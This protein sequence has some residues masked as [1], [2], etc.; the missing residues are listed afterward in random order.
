MKNTCIS[1][2]VVLFMLVF[3][4]NNCQKRPIDT[5]KAGFVKPHDSVQTSVYWYWI[6]DNISEEG[7]VKDLQA[8]KR[9]GINRAF[10]GNIGLDS[11]PPY[12]NVKVFSQEWWNILHVA[13][14]TATEL[15]IDIGMFNSPGWS[16]SGGPWVTPDQAMRFITS[17][18]LLVEGGKTIDHRLLDVTDGNRLFKVIAY[19]VPVDYGK[20]LNSTN[21]SVRSTPSI[22]SLQHVMDNNK[23]T[24]IQ[25]KGDFTL[26]FKS[27]DLYTVRSLLIYTAP[28]VSVA[29]CEFQAKNKEGVLVP[30]T[31]FRI[32]RS[33]YNPNV[34]FD[35]SAPIVVSFADVV[36]NEFRL[37]FKRASG[38]FGLSEVELSSLPMVERYP[39]KT[40]AKMFQQPLPYW[41]EYQWPRQQETESPGTT[42][43]PSAIVDLTHLVSDGVLH[44]DAPEGQWVLLCTG[45]KP[46]GVTNAP[47]AL[48]ATGLEVDK[49]SKKHV[50]SHFDAFI[51]EI[52]RRIPARDRRSFKVVVADSYETGG[53]NYSDSLFAEFKERY[54]YDPLPFLPVYSGKVVGSRLMSDRFLWDMR[55]LIA[56]KVAYDYVGG[57]REAAHQNGL[58]TW[59]ENYGHWGFP[60]EFLQYGGQSDE[61]GGEFWSFGSLGDIENRA[62]SSCGH[63]YGKQKISAES[64]TCSVN[65]PYSLHPAQMKQRG[66]RFFAEGINNTLLHVYIQQPDERV[67]GMNAWFGNEFNRHNTWF[68]QMDLF[69]DYLKRTNYMLQQGLNVADIAYFIGEDAPKMTGITEP[70]PPVGYQFDYINAEVILRDM[71]VKEGLLTLPHGTQYKILVLPP[72]ETMRPQLLAKIKSLIAAG[73]VVLG[74]APKY[75]PSLQHQPQAD[76]DVRAMAAEIWGEVDGITV[77][78][79]TYGKGKI[80]NGMS[81]EQAFELLNVIPDCKLPLSNEIHYGHRKWDVIDIYFISNQTNTKQ[82]VAPAFRVTGKQ[83]QVWN[84]VNGSIRT[85]SAFTSGDQFTSIPL[86]LAPYESYFVVFSDKLSSTQA[87]AAEVNFPQLATIAEMQAPWT[88]RF[89]A[90]AKGTKKDAQ[91]NT[92]IDWSAHADST[93]QHYSGQASYTNTFRLN[94]VPKNKVEIDLGK[95]E[96]MAKVYVN[97]VYAGGV[98]TAPYTI[99][100]TKLVKQG[101]NSIQVDVVNTWANHLIG[102]ARLPESERT[103]YA[104]INP[105]SANSTLKP[106]GLIGP[107]KIVGE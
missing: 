73:G 58:T 17:S 44:W 50:A 34:G 39:E 30:I 68:V 32:D 79:R 80:L 60:G 66:D 20:R 25:Q 76:Q 11:Q 42:I 72:L 90:P 41:V 57:L 105:W 55:R 37:V 103:S 106:S 22:S 74:P 62:A 51:G 81:M 56:D 85:L 18:E 96:V 86:E 89:D 63:I 2:L 13:L 12:G 36:S 4:T 24:F 10:I 61:I 28:T 88:V 94:D 5:L 3:L 91:F 52:L 9:V 71:T 98:W 43:D 27:H 7:V 87:N 19:P 93:I 64:F 15:G 40:L 29:D 8:M 45:T 82:H 21:A 102:D 97:G 92:L 46:T 48:E 69:V 70:A 77:K 101:D 6:N 1:S 47:A 107:V 53:Q 49:M 14:K 99:D 59:L 83:A 16:Q 104:P 38:N 26:D 54:Q 31:T 95:V 84:A 65:E 33:N 35:P 23:S 78:H 75:S 67:P 100:I